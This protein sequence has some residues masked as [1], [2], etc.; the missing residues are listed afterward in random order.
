MITVY[1]RSSRRAAQVARSQLAVRLALAVYAALVVVVA[2]RVIVLFLG[3]PDSVW[4][5]AFLLGASA[6]AVL[7]LNLV[8]GAE[9]A[10]IRSMT[11]ADLTTAL[12]LV[13][14]PLPFL[15]R[16]RRIHH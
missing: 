10:V 5:V 7:P 14:L 12:V 2:L 8:P 4:S 9:R 16:R 6:P 1:G 13:A 11:M 15:G 3:F